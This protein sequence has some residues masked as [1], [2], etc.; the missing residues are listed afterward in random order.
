MTI[1]TAR[2]NFNTQNVKV[3]LLGQKEMDNDGEALELRI[4]CK[5]LDWQLSALAQVLNSLLSSLPTL[6]GLEIEVS[7]EYWQGGRKVSRENLQGEIEVSQWREFFLPFIFVKQMILESED[8][9]RLVAP[10]LQELAKE[11]ATV[12]PALQ[13]LSIWRNG[14]RRS[15]KAIKRFIATRQLYGHPVTVHYH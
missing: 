15:R 6:E 7:Q 2:V 10:A 13:K 3:I 4:S 11:R 9:I 5:P 1:H 14:R 12:L 8:A